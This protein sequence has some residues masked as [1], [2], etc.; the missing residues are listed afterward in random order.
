M[1]VS[2]GFDPVHVGHIRF[3]KAARKLGDE[4][5]I[6]LNND[7]WVHDK[8]GYVFMPEEDRKVILE[9]LRFVDRVVISR[10]KKNDKDRTVSRELAALKPTAAFFANAGDAQKLPPVEDAACKR[11]GI[12]PV[13]LDVGEKR[14]SSSVLAKEVAKKLRG[15]A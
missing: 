9:S 7:N 2:G 12:K 6:L 11:L 13:F 5:V 10:H 4:L 8:K 15:K 3:L 14:H 1:A